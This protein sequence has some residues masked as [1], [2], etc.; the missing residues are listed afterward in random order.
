MICFNIS[1][2]SY[3][4]FK[5]SPLIF[6]F[7]HIVKS[8]PDTKVNTV[9]GE[10]GKLVH[11]LLDKYNGDNS[12]DVSVLFDEKWVEKKLHIKNGFGNKP[13]SKTSFKKSLKNGK[14]LINKVYNNIIRCEERIVL[15]FIE[16]DDVKIK[17]KGFIDFVAK[18]D[19][20]I[21]IGDWKTNGSVGDFTNHAK[22]Y[23]LLYWRKHNV[24]PKRLVYE[25]LRINQTKTY[26][27]TKEDI[28]I[29]EEELKHFVK[30]IKQWGKNI[31]HYELGDIDSPFNCHKKKCLKEKCDR[32]IV[33]S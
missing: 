16:D 5:Q 28:I 23:A 3:G 19:G 27:F 6:Y 4:L 18:K 14:D 1:A 11:G 25:Y 13:L 7:Q 15:P 29:F 10:A 17:L 31:E 22:M 30:K 24:F 8:K 20:D 33:H 26:D 9:Y 21:I 2:S 32:R 12:I